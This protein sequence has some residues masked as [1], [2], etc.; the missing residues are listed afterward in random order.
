MAEVAAKRVRGRFPL[1]TP[2]TKMGLSQAEL[3][4]LSPRVK[5]L[6]KAD[7]V[8]MWEGKRSEATAALTVSDINSIRTAFGKQIKTGLPADI[9]GLAAGDIN[10]C[11]CCCPCCCAESV[12]EPVVVQ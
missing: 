2:I 8:A 12:T 9:G 1:T 4:A 6:T 11:C 3:E 5:S 10:C 7:L